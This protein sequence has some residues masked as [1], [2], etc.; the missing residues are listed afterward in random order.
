MG[1]GY[2]WFATDPSGRLY[3]MNGDKHGAFPRGTTLEEFDPLPTRRP[4]LDG[5]SSEQHR[6]APDVT[7]FVHHYAHP[8]D[9]DRRDFYR[10][11]RVEELPVRLHHLT[12]SWR[13][14]FGRNVLPLGP[15]EVY[16]REV[17]GLDLT[18]PAW[19]PVPRYGPA[20]PPADR[21]PLDAVPAMSVEELRAALP[22]PPP[23]A[24]EPGVR[25]AYDRSGQVAILNVPGD[26]AAEALKGFEDRAFHFD[27]IARY[28]PLEQ[29]LER[30][31]KGGLRWSDLDP[32]ARAL[33]WMYFDG[34]FARVEE[35]RLEDLTDPPPV[36][37]SAADQADASDE[38]DELDDDWF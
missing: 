33:A 7:R 18:H 17:D 26:T 28:R 35:F 11:T 15:A 14:V 37:P 20:E 25:L 6:A 32:D 22:S 10:R 24:T 8:N 3:V 19:P 34:D 36:A 16:L 38:A 27:P 23:E 13:A 31:K 1:V 30:S 21:T 2:R 9:P 5:M 4:W 29:P 12:P